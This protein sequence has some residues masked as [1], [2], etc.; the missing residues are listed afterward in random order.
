YQNINILP[1]EKVDDALLNIQ[2]DKADAALL[3]PTIAKKFKKKH[4]EIQILDIPLDLQDQVQGIGIMLKKN[5]Q[6]LATQINNAIANL[7][8]EGIINFY[9]NKWDIE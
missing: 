8:K 2:Y 6:I 1:T 3:E 5:N 9:E 7:K 4:P